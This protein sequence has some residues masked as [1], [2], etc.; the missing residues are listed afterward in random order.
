MSKV[1]RHPVAHF[2]RIVRRR[3]VLLHRGVRDDCAATG[4]WGARRVHDEPIRGPD[5]IWEG[6][7]GVEGVGGQWGGI[8]S[9]QI[10][11]QA[12]VM[13]ITFTVSLLWWELHECARPGKDP[14]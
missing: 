10:A 8:A 12:E 2:F 3:R 13:C 14:P 4:G 1:F 7:E 11:R 5:P 9:A 6:D